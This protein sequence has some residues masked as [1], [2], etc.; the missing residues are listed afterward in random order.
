M[1]TA[2][3]SQLLYGG[4]YNPE[5][6]PESVWAEDAELMKRAGVNLVTVGVFS[7]AKLQP[8]SD[9]YTFEW[10]DRIFDLLHQN[11]VLIDLATATASP[12]PWFSKMHPESLPVNAEGVRL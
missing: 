9:T 6:W 3:T 8:A 2:R 12:P 11:Q 10:L 1:I 7:W 4:D 5:Q